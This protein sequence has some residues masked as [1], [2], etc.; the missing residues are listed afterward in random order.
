MKAKNV[1]I[2]VTASVACYKALDVINGLRK[3]GAGVTV[4]LT[5]ETEGFIKPVLFQSVSGNKVITHDMFNAPDEWD[6]AHISLARKADCFAIIPATANIIG[7]IANGICDDMLTCAV[8]ATEAP[9]LLAPA[10]NT[11]MYRN[12][13]VQANIKKLKQAGYHFT[14]PIEGCL[15]CGIKGMGHI[16]DTGIIIKEIKQLIG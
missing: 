12:K 5:K 3:L 13:I 15:A 4:V 6:P 16:Q 9:V 1:V 2:G 10:M 8:C 7:K 14:G 11:G